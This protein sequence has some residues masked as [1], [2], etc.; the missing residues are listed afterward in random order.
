[1]EHDESA[2]RNS[3]TA[4]LYIEALCEGLVPHHTPGTIFQQD[5]ARIHTANIVPSWFESRG[6]EV[7]DWPAHSP[8]M[9]PIEPV[10]RFLKLKIFSMF[11]EL[12]GRLAVLPEAGIQAFENRT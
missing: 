7:V 12:I 11:P 3:Y 5:N 9:S 8:D 10:S 1:M 2:A 6:V 4:N